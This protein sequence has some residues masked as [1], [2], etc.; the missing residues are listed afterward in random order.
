MDCR[1]TSDLELKMSV[2]QKRH[3]EASEDGIR[4]CQDD[5]Q[6]REMARLV[7]D[8]FQRDNSN[9]KRGEFLKACGMEKES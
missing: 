9:F 8:M 6:A 2:F 1:E 5:K 7:S 4:V 3:Y